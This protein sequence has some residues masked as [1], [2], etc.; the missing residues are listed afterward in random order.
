MQCQ[1]SS[2]TYGTTV[3]CLHCRYGEGGSVASAAKSGAVGG[4]RRPGPGCCCKELSPIPQALFLIGFVI[5]IL[6]ASPQPV[7]SADIA[8]VIKHG[9]P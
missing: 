1:K 9:L 3:S 4:G 7:E 5:E 6:T 2:L 8:A